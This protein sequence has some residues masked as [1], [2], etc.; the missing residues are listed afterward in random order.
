MIQQFLLGFGVLLIVGGFLLV[1]DSPPE[2]FLRQSNAQIEDVPEADSYMTTVE[3]RR[4]SESGVQQFNLSAPRLEFFE[5]QSTLNI[6]QPTFVTATPKQ[7]P[8][9]L[10]AANGILINDGEQLTLEGNVRATLY[11]E[12]GR[13]TL[14]TPYLIY[15]VE[16]R[17]AK[18][19]SQFRLSSPQTI[20]TG[21]GL[22]ADFG[23][24]VYTIKSK[25]RATHEPI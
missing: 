10:E 2:A 23:N 5:Q 7:E 12:S 14:T 4:F 16:N 24:T 18:T 25:V 22:T 15:L 21:K 1:W 13:N 17:T 8:L 9:R 6:S 20:V 11:Q 19:N 3:S